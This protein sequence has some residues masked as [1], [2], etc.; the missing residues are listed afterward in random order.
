MAG[1]AEGKTESGTE[2]NTSPDACSDMSLH[3]QPAAA[4]MMPPASPV[5][6]EAAFD[7]WLKQELT[8][9]YDSALSEP[10]PPELLQLLEKGSEPG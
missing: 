2:P 1:E 3:L 5:G 7:R 10:V 6:T 8:R 9:L 4:P